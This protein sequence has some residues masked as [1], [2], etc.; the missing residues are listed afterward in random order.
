[1]A[2]TAIERQPLTHF[3]GNVAADPEETKNGGATKFR[4]AVSDGF[5]EDA[6]T[7]FYDVVATKDPMREAIKANI[8]KGTKVGVTGTEKSEVYNDK[9]YYTIFP[10]QVFLAQNIKSLVAEEF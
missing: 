10:V 6:N 7:I 8:S 5:G 4:L 9:T 1:M 2:T 3:I